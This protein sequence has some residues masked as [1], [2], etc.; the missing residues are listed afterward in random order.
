MDTSN[1]SGIKD[2]LDRVMK[3]IQEIVERSVGEDY[4][5]RGEAECYPK[6]SS[7]LYRQ[8][9]GDFGIEDDDIEII[10]EVMILSMAK[11]YLDQTDEL[12][13]LTELQHYGGKTNL[14]DFTA[15]Y[16]IALFFA[17]EGSRDRDGRII[18]LK[19]EKDLLNQIA[20]SLSLKTSNNRF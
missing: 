6:V 5:F 16:L 19:K 11:E 15:D 18:L 14:I 3:K 8:Y 13:I 20:K 12:G 4:I 1:R 2:E 17:C 9:G 10:Q 7:G